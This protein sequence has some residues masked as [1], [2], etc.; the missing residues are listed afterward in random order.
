MIT[1]KI[2]LEMLAREHGNFLGPE[3]F[4]QYLTGQL[5]PVTLNVT[6]NVNPILRKYD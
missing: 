2:L 1:R 6:D 3:T 5:R 4:S